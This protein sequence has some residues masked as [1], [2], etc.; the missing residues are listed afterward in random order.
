MSEIIADLA[1]LVAIAAAVWG[2][3]AWVKA[4]LHV[5]AAVA[6]LPQ[7]VNG[8]LD[9]VLAELRGLRA[10]QLAER[11]RADQL[12]EVGRS[13]LGSVDQGPPA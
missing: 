12:A 10:D 5:R 4:A 3:I 9:Q 7:L 1:G 6:A 2:G 8:R 11:L 13:P